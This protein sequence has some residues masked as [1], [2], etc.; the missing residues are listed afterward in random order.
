ME[1]NI[2]TA[3]DGF[4]SYRIYRE[5]PENIIYSSP[6]YKNLIL[7][8][9]LSHIKSNSI[10]STIR[11][12]DFGISTTTPSVSD[13]GILNFAFPGFS[14]F[15]NV[16][17]L[18]TLSTTTDNKTTYSSFFVTRAASQT[19]NLKE[20]AIK[21][22]SLVN[23]FARQLVDIT[24]ERGDGVEFVYNVEV[25]WPEYKTEL[26][27][28]LTY[29]QGSSAIFVSGTSTVPLTAI[30]LNDK[31]TGRILYNEYYVYTLSSAD[32]TDSDT[33]AYSTTDYANSYAITT[34]TFISPNTAIDTTRFAPSVGYGP[35]KSFL[36]CK[37]Q[38]MVVPASANNVWNIIWNVPAP[39]ESA[40]AKTGEIGNMYWVDTL[41]GTLYKPYTASAT[42]N[43][44]LELVVT[45][46]W[47]P[48]RG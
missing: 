28:T 38:T 47:G 42:V 39:M 48:Y 1:L 7:N 11:Y 10:E 3:V 14:M 35:I 22:G 29:T 45:H 16:L 8:S 37:D 40:I 30:Y 18:S 21:P 5:N 25:T 19:T 24:L 41:P 23:A 6:V 26:T 44:L 34:R 15:S 27:S 36:I 33:Y 4:F 2:K 9:G 12:V 31:S 32:I 13:T 43:N 17:A 20:F 46:T